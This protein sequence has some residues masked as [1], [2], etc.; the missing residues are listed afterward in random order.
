MPRR[1]AA[2][3]K[4]DWS[5]EYI[6]YRIR[7]QYGSMV[8]MAGCYGL[9]PSVIKRALSVPYPKVERTIAIA[10]G[11]TPEAIWPSRYDPELLRTNR[12][13][14]RRLGNLKSISAADAAL[15]ETDQAN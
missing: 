9:D 2:K 13:L 1:P 3:L 12:R 6:K 14:W 5:R 15:V 7:A 10:L 4:P 11:T 8:A